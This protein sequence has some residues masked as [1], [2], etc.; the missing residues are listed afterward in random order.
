MTNTIKIKDIDK[1]RKQILDALG[2][3]ASEYRYQVYNSGFWGKKRTHSMKG[4]KQFTQVSIDFIEHSIKAN[5]RQDKL[6]HAYN[7]LSVNNK[8]FSINYL[9]EML[10]GQVAVLSAK[11]LSAKEALKVLD[12]LKNSA[13]FRQ[14]QYSYLLY[15]NKELPGFLQR[16]NIPAAEVNSS[17][18][19]KTLL[20]KNNQLI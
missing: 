9:S 6:Y 18:L 15:P 8:S 3:A 16:N 13:L 5:Q 19:L 20:Q 12:G 14:D 17:E 7:L 2:Q 11:F 4:L 1:N 10:E